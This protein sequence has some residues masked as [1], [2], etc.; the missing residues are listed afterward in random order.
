[1]KEEARHMARKGDILIEACLSAK[2]DRD[3]GSG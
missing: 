1:M 3:G 2:A